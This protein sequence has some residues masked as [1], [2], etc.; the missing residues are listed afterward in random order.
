M[1]RSINKE[2]KKKENNVSRFKP[3]IDVSGLGET[4]G[5]NSWK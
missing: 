2:R 1:H 4:S 3:S 5:D